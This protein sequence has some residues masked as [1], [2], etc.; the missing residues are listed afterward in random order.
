MVA[1]VGRQVVPTRERADRSGARG[2]GLSDTTTAESRTAGGA[3]SDADRMGSVVAVVG[4]DRGPRRCRSP[5]RGCRRSRGQLVEDD[6]DPDRNNHGELVQQRRNDVDHDRAEHNDDHSRADDDRR[7]DH[8]LATNH[9][10]PADDLATDDESSDHATATAAH[11][12]IERAAG[13]PPGLV[14]FAAWCCRSDIGRYR[15]DLFGPFGDRQAVHAAPL[16]IRVTG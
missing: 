9:T 13:R 5:D 16:A 4:Q 15:D 8:D 1:G 10:T 7:S 2:A 12:I 6:C 3:A 11:H 14:L